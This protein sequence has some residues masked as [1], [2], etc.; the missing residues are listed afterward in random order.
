[1]LQRLP[2]SS[3]HAPAF[4][5]YIRL[6]PELDITAT[7]AMQRDE[8]R[9]LFASVDATRG[10]FRYA[11]GKWSIREIA[12]HFSDAERVFGYRLLCIARGEQADLPGFEEDD[13]IAAAHYD[14]WSMDDLVAHFVALRDAN[15]LLLR[16]L[17]AD[18]WNRR[19]VANGNP[20]SVR[21]IAYAIAGHVRHHVGVLRERYSV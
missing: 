4:G 19:G 6:V 15:I 13:Y 1:M 12:G 17:R 20:I 9:Q 2:D 8:V 14:D 5:A 10:G 21:A 11:E 16:N 18:D 7:L 3:E